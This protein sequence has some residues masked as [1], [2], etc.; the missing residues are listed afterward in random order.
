MGVPQL[1]R[2][3]REVYKQLVQQTGGVS[4]NLCAQDFDPV[5]QDMAKSVVQDSKLSCDYAI[6]PPPGGKM[7]DA[8]KVNVAYTPGGQGMPQQI[9]NVPGGIGDCG[10][11][12]GWYYDNPSAPTKILM[13][14]STC[15]VLQADQAGKV[16]IL[17]GCDTVIGPPA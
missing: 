1:D 16:E 17:F 5:F 8:S 15:A 6:P 9:L 4:G 13:C 14:P 2:A 3:Q 11:N 12:G 10:Q 7:F